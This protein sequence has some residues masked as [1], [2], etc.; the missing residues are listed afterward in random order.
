L[1]ALLAGCFA[2]M[3]ADDELLKNSKGAQLRAPH[4][5]L[6]RCSL[7]RVRLS[8]AHLACLPLRCS[9]HG[10]RGRHRLRAAEDAGAERLR[11]HRDGAR[12]AALVRG[13]ARHLVSCIAAALRSSAAAGDDGDT[14]A[15]AT[16]VVVAL[17]QA[18]V[19]DARRD[20]RASTAAAHGAVMA[21][22]DALRARAATLDE[23]AEAGD[24][25]G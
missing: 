18:D 21:A 16:P 1:H 4:A 23:A 6:Q 12:A 17:W 25:L 11:G 13:A 5:M 8:A 2:A 22:E 7:C 14:P 20:G 10:R 3:S 15:A 19:T 9:A 24:V